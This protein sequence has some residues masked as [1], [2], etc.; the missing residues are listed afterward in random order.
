MYFFVLQLL[1][2]LQADRMKIHSLFD[3]NVTSAATTLV[4]RQDYM[5]HA[6]LQLWG[7]NHSKVKKTL[8]FQSGYL[9]VT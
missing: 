9:Y 4:M 3:I 8:A 5:Y 2:V 6:F 7:V 1:Q